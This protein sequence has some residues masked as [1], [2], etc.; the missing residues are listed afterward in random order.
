[1]AMLTVL[2]CVHAELVGTLPPSVKAS[3]MK[4]LYLSF[5]KLSGTIEDMFCT[6]E[7]DPLEVCCCYAPGGAICL[8]SASASTQK[9]TEMSDAPLEFHVP[10]AL[11]S[12]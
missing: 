8:E 5:N 10:T 4:H 7:I 3:N 2:L 1:M 9:P 6:Q 12:Q 11:D